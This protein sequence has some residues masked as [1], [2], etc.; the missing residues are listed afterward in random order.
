MLC[1]LIDEIIKQNIYLRK[2][3]VFTNGTI[4]SKKIKKYLLKIGNYCKNISDSKINKETQRWISKQFSD[5]YN[6]DSYATIIISTTGHRN[7]DIDSTINFYN[8]DVDNNILC[9]YNQDKAFIGQKDNS[10]L[11]EG[12]GLKNFQK[13][14]DE[15]YKHFSIVNNR[16][17]VIDDFPYDINNKKEEEIKRISKA[18]TISANGNVFIGCSQ[19]FENVDNEYKIFNIMDCNNNFYKLLDDFSWKYPLSEGQNNSKKNFLI[20]KWNYEHNLPI[21]T[22]FEKNVTNANSQEVYNLFLTILQLYDEFEKFLKEIHEK[23]PLFNHWEC[24]Q[25][26]LYVFCYL[27]Y[28]NNGNFLLQ[29]L[30][31]YTNPESLEKKDKSDIEEMIEKL[32]I[33]YNNK[34]SKSNLLLNFILQ[35]C[36]GFIKK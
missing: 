27:N 32:T 23:Y 33:I 21:N 12:N 8:S 5:V 31:G 11:L 4:K 30:S 7:I 14:Y 3:L 17:C 6:T 13:F 9:V 2:F 26:A 28:D 10:I 18:I 36:E 29:I 1:Y 15:G 22:L 19:S 34:E 16:Y 35:L 25:F 24:N 20:G